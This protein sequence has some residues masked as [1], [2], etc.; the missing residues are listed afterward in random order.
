MRLVMF[1]MDGTLIDTQALILEHMMATFE[2]VG[3]VPPTRARPAG[4]SACRCPSPWNG[5]RAM[6]MPS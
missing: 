4:L 6:T 5:W 1:D 2:T 3:L